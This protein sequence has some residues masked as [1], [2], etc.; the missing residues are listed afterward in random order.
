ME[1]TATNLE[2]AFLVHFQKIE[3]H[4]GFFARGWCRDEFTKHGLNPNMLQLNVGFSHK[5]GTLRGLHVQE[6]PYEEAKLV[7][8]TRG[9]IYDVIVDL[10]RDSPTLGHWIGTELTADSG[11]M[12]YAPEGFAHGY[13]T[14]TDGTEMNYMTTEVY[15]PAAAKGILYNDPVLAIEWPLPVSVIS[16]QDQNWPNYRVYCTSGPAK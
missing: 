12:V 3:D 4:R 14:M 16:D 2:G 11:V 9:A 1:F 5:K 13:Q 8:C 15:V 10:R 7:R 6:K